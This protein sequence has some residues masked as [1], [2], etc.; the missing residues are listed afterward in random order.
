MALDPVRWDCARCGVSSGQID[1]KRIPL[2]PSWTQAGERSFCLSC[3]RALAGEAA[4]DSAPADS[5]REDLVRIRRRGLIEFE[6]RRAPE[7][8]NR[9]I[10]QACRTSTGAVAA[11]R[12]A[13][14]D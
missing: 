3:S 5:S 12:D 11:V 14:E 7:A 13:G 9:T 10:A 4:Q 1:G 2:P 6:I 8:P